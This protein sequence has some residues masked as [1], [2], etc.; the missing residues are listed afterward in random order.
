LS[1]QLDAGVARGEYPRQRLAGA[2][3]RRTFS[4]ETALSRREAA[5][6]LPPRRRLSPASAAGRGAAGRDRPESGWTGGAA[7][8]AERSTHSE[9]VPH[10]GGGHRNA[11]E[12]RLLAGGTATGTGEDVELLTARRGRFSLFVGRISNPS[13]P[14]PDGLQIRPT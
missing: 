6:P 12:I 4:D 1:A 7:P 11:G 3:K 13:V 10:A 9:G 2:G 5:R 14:Q 8:R